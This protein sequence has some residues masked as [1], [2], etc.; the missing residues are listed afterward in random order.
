M[1]LNINKVVQ[2]TALCCLKRL[3]KSSEMCLCALSPGFLLPTIPSRSNREI[4]CWWMLQLVIV[5]LI[6]SVVLLVSQ[7]LWMVLLVLPQTI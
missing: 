6:M 4:I 2:T 7:L 1:E 3:S 5:T